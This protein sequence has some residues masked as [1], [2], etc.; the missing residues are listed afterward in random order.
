MRNV[1]Q[2]ALFNLSE[3]PSAVQRKA[4]VTTERLPRLDSN[5]QLRPKLLPFCRLAAGDIWEDPV[6]GHRVG[7]L[8][9]TVPA[10]VKRVTKGEQA[11]LIVNDPPYNVVVGNANTPNLSKTHICA[12]VEFSR[13]W[14]ENSLAVLSADGSLYV[15]MGADYR[16]NF[17]P[18]PDFMVLMRD[19]QDV[20]KP[21]NLITV[22]NQRGYGTPCNWM[23]VRQ[24]LLY[25][26]RSKASFNVAAEYT[27]IPKVLRGYYKTVNGV[28]TE[29]MER[30]KS[31]NIRA[32]NVWIDVQQVFYRLE[33]NVS[34]CYAQ[35]PLKAIERIISA[36]SSRGDLVLDFFSHSGSTLLAG[37]RL[38]RRVFTFDVD[39][40][41]AEL[42]IRRIENYRLTGKTGWQWRNPFPELDR[43]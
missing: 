15:W 38:G 10:D 6:K 5:P 25:Y 21:R 4:G 29:N 18:L 19:Y 12:Y 13:R 11:T 7:V 34:G 16:D 40:V 42:T 2:A 33:E 41:F 8:D 27:D 26:A 31:E 30:S 36:S 23:W 43:Q 32:G 39:P 35:K 17:Q 1:T 20:I 9:A 14:V 3:E 22:R 24:E 28:V 37:E